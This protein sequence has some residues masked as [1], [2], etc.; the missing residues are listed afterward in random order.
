MKIQ[1][2]SDLHLEFAPDFVPGNTDADVLILAGDI[3][4]ANYFQ[5]SEDSPYYERAQKAKDFLLYCANHYKHVIY[6]MGNHEHYYSRWH[7]TA[8][9]LVDIIRDVNA[10][11]MYGHIVF[12]DKGAIDIDG[13][14][15]VGGTLWTDCN[16]GDAIAEMTVESSLYDYKIITHVSNGIYRKLRMSDTVV[17]HQKT[18]MFFD[19]AIK[20][21]EQAVVIS[22]HA[23]SEQSVHE[24]YKNKFYLNAGYRSVLDQ[25][26]LDRPQI[27]LW[28]HGHMH[29]CFDYKIGGTRV[30]CNP[31]GYN[32][33]NP[34]FNN[35]LVVEL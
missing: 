26:I 6:I 32:D 4:V 33:E 28:F 14:L 1:Y 27:K 3:L 2:M 30:L 31:R 12:L 8:G 17:E 29:D 11:S 16:R 21:A 22:H 5:R 34:S 18:L 9:T 35:N 10:A 19:E 25:F 23:P 7:E 24:K 13:T 15:F 20:D